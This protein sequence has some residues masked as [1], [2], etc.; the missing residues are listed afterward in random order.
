LSGADGENL[1][2]FTLD[3]YTQLC[4]MADARANKKLSL[5]EYVSESIRNFTLQDMYEGTVCCRDG[6]EGVLQAAAAELAAAAS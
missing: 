2:S 5:T 6:N 3:P 1:G 4:L